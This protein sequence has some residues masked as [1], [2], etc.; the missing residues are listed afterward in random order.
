VDEF[1]FHIMRNKTKKGAS[2][3]GY[4]VATPLVA[5]TSTEAGRIAKSFV[6]M[7]M[8]NATGAAAVYELIKTFP[9][10]G[11]LDREFRWF[12][13]MMDAIATELMSRVEFGVKVRAGMGAGLSFVDMVSDTL[14]IKKYFAS[15]QAHFAKPLLA[16]VGFNVGWQVAIVLVQ[17]VGLKKNRLRTMFLE[18]AAVVTCIKPGKQR[19]ISP[20]HPLL[21]HI[22]DTQ[23][24]TRGEWQ[25]VK[26]RG[27]GPCLVP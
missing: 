21:T 3:M 6:M 15:G 27:R 4:Q 2:Q 5:I 26:S 11:D 1:L 10:M 7:L 14:I 17:T 20:P 12:R 9:A 25:A 22:L 24:W 8:S 23:A 19:H 18:S 16:C 13:P